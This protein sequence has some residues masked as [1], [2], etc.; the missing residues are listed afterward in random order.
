MT[1][2]L[3]FFKLLISYQ[4]WSLTIASSPVVGSS[5][6]TIELSLGEARAKA[7][8]SLLFSPPLKF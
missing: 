8:L 6:I 5:R 3:P 2:H 1:M 7:I 4:T